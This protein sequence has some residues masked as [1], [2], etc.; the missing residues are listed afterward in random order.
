[1]YGVTHGRT[2]AMIADGPGQRLQYCITIGTEGA[3]SKII[4]TLFFMPSQLSSTI[5]VL[6]WSS[7]KPVRIASRHSWYIWSPFNEVSKLLTLGTNLACLQTLDFSLICLR[8]R[9]KVNMTGSSGYLWKVSVPVSSTL[10]MRFRRNEFLICTV[11]YHLDTHTPQKHRKE[12]GAWYVENLSWGE[13]LVQ[14]L[15]TLSKITNQLEYIYH[16]L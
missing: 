13:R 12:G 1:M 8:M 5:G 11:R 3:A 14:R 9:A 7:S 15:P 10:K 6:A 4:L 2:H 16:L